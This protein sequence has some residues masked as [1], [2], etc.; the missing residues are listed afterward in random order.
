MTTSLVA[1]RV[2]NNP[3]F[4]KAHDLKPAERRK[5][6]ELTRRNVEYIRPTEV[7][8]AFSWWQNHGKVPRKLV[9]VPQAY[10]WKG[11]RNYYFTDSVYY[12]ETPPA[13]HTPI[14]SGPFTIR[15]SDYGFSYADMFKCE[16]NATN[17]ALGTPDWFRGDDPLVG[18]FIGKLG[19]VAWLEAFGGVMVVVI[20]NVRS[21]FDI[22]Y[23]HGSKNIKIDIKTSRDAF[24]DINVWNDLLQTKD[25]TKTLADVFILAHAD[26]H[27]GVVTFQGGVTRQMLLTQGE[28]VD[29]KETEHGVREKYQLKHSAIIPNLKKILDMV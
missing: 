9:T 1:D 11:F 8:K 6:V 5:I 15:V 19:E 12:Y 28:V 4:A 16:G 23:D 2:L 10:T 21:P 3:A 18:E 26:Q 17:R 22:A 7:I 20:T 13:G 27:T 24:S 25:P 29:R 14:P